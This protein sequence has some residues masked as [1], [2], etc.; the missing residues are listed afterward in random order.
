MSD[1]S[2]VTTVLL[3]SK[4]LNQAS[5]SNKARQRIE[6]TQTK[7]SGTQKSGSICP[8]YLVH[9]SLSRFPSNVDVQLATCIATASM[10]GVITVLLAFLTCKARNEPY[11]QEHK[12]ELHISYLQVE[13]CVLFRCSRRPTSF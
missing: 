5:T 3:A 7:K 9:D 10:V 6:L 12:K 4:C 8:R 1:L 11:T 13:N 2:K